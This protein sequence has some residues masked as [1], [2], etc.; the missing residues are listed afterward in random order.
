MKN[1][2]FCL[3]FALMGCAGQTQTPIPAPLS[4]AT[5]Y[6]MPANKK[7]VL[8]LPFGGTITVKTGDQ[9]TLQ[10]RA[11][12][13]T[14]KDEYRS[15]H[16]VEVQDSKDK[17]YI[18]TGYGKNLEKRG[19]NCFSCDS[20]RTHNMWISNDGG[21]MNCICLQVNYEI[22]VPAGTNLSI[23]TISGDIEIRGHTGAL[24]VKS[25]SG[26]VDMDLPATANARLDIQSVTGEIYTDHNLKL[27][28]NS[29]DYDK[30]IAI[31]LGKG[32]ESIV[33]ETV[34]GDIFFRKR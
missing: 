13:T 25:I 29:T 17:L 28:E 24:T 7:A 31:S 2:L 10:F 14:E 12:I 26:F 5:V 27:D 34:S 9:P 33:L 1:T 11:L 15:L 18:E 30:N 4:D 19:I 6:A 3:L 32:G 8:N 22:T 21:K 20:T 23:E 16:E